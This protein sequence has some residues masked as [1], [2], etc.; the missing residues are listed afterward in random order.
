MIKQLLVKQFRIFHEKSIRLYPGINVL[1]GSNGI[2]KTSLLEA[3]YFLN[4]TKSFKAARDDDMIR[5]GEDHFHIESEWEQA[6]Y[7]RAEVNV[8][9]NQGKRFIYDN[10]IISRNS[11]IVGAFPMVL[12]SQEDFRIS[13]GGGSDR[14]L[15]FDRFNSQYSPAHMQDLI[16][17]RRLLKQR[18]AALKIQSEK[19]NYRYST[20]LE[21]YDLQLSPLMHRIAVFR[22]RIT[23]AFNREL[24]VLYE[25]TFG[26]QDAA[27]IRYRPSLEA[28][29]EAEF[30][31][32]H[33]EQVKNNIDKEIAL[34]R[35]LWG[36]N[37]DKYIFYRKGVPLIHYASQGEH[38]IWL[39]LLKLAE[40]EIIC[41]K[42]GEEPLYLFD[43]L[44]AELD[45]RNSQRI[46]KQIRNKKQALISTTDLN[47]LRM[48]GMDVGHKGIHIIKID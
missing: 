29:N 18:N 3:I 14:R 37:Y 12:L 48:H 28:E 15:Y 21:V 30:L 46:V 39:T 26:E 2:G 47:D 35:S 41:K 34:R 4:F 17:Y 11:D 5:I 20:E 43:D 1:L 9:K 42:V 8:V 36:P 31:K 16:L 40:G 27:T 25:S 33:M 22:K 10:E 45:I 13:G 44:F 7:R 24:G 6:R 19:K 38:K 32:K 23:T